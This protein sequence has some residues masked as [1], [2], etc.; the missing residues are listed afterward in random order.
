[1]EHLCSP[2]PRSFHVINQS[3][4]RLYEL[5]TQLESTNICTIPSENQEGRILELKQEIESLSYL[6]KRGYR[7]DVQVGTH[8][9]SPWVDW[10]VVKKT[11]HDVEGDDEAAISV[12]QIAHGALRMA[13]QKS[14][15]GRIIEIDDL[16]SIVHQVE[17]RL[18]VTLGTDIPG[19][20]A[21]D[22]AFMFSL[23]GITSPTLYDQLAKISYNELKRCGSRA[24]FK[25][26]YIIH[27]VEK[28]VA[29]GLTSQPHS[30]E[31]NDNH[32]MLKM[33]N[34]AA[35]LLLEKKG[36]KKDEPLINALFSNE[37]DIFYGRVPLWLWRFSSTQRKLVSASSTQDHIS[38]KEI[39]WSDLF[40]DPCKPLVVDVGSGMG[41]SILGLASTTDDAHENKSERQATATRFHWDE[42]NFVG[43]DINPILTNYANGLAQRW[44]MIGKKVQFLTLSAEEIITQATKNYP[45]EIKL[46]MIQ[47]PTP[48]RLQSKMNA[49]LDFD[50]DRAS[51]S[52]D[53]VIDNR[54]N[55]QLPED[56]SNSSG[57]MAKDKLLRLIANALASKQ[58]QKGYLLL[59]SNCEDV[60]VAMKKMAED[61]ASFSPVDLDP[62]HTVWCVGDMYQDGKQF[63][64]RSEKW[65]TYQRSTPG[66]QRAEGAGWS[67]VPILPCKGASETEVSCRI[68]GKPIHRCL[69]R[70]EPNV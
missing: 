38:P 21:T 67:S 3:V 27:M 34:L 15:V 65:A 5:I 32:I 56:S 44:G 19:S 62:S 13:Q 1:M 57:F 43:A 46:I 68:E 14:E 10:N 8:N 28:L 18:A 29:S 66:Q 17:K 31:L 35:Q 52:T 47:F 41:L 16:H 64:R 23:V 40:E 70:H 24:S 55:S 26:K 11:A 9:S 49:T 30:K 7:I 36:W 22:A 54:G 39:D 20:Q 51:D 6:V 53:G 69:L 60:A 63:S 37:I 25:A 42:Y 33:Y 50:S 45:G 59:Q 12:L 48:F 4:L 58:K 61:V 2:A